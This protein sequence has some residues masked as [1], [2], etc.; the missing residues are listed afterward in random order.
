VP[1]N[2][3]FHLGS[4][5]RIPALR[6]AVHLAVVPSFELALAMRADRPLGMTSNRWT[7][8]VFDGQEILGFGAAHLVYGKDCLLQVAAARRGIAC[9]L[10]GPVAVNAEMLLAVGSGAHVGGAFGGDEVVQVFH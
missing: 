1:A 2:G 10:A 8:S 7:G 9:E 6:R 5:G 3:V 4:A